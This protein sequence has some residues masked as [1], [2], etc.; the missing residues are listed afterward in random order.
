MQELNAGT[1][2]DCK[3]EALA[4]RRYLGATI[5]RTTKTSRL[6]E[7]ASVLDGWRVAEERHLC[8]PA[9]GFGDSVQ[10]LSQLVEILGHQ[11]QSEPFDGRGWLVAA[12]DKVRHSHAVT[13]PVA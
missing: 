12:G 3:P 4:G 5:S 6:A 7:T 2:P 1:P 8:R 13:G 11:L 9:F 10:R